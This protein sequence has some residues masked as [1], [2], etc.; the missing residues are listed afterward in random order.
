VQ[1]FLDWLDTAKVSVIS[2][3]LLA[4]LG[5]WFGAR[6]ARQSRDHDAA[7]AERQRSHEATIERERRRHEKLADLYV[8]LLEFVHRGILHAA[9]TQPVIGPPPPPPDLHTDLALVLLEARVDAYASE[10]VQSLLGTWG[11]ARQKFYIV[12]KRLD[13][14]DETPDTWEEL[15]KLRSELL[16]TATAMGVRI[17]LELRGE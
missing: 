3:A 12:A 7:E 16:T 9:R 14:P 15:E 2:S 11:S 4:A 8:D 5:I 17:N 1:D 6:T 13:R 10:E